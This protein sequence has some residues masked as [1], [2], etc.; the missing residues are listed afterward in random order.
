MFSSN[1]K[2]NNNN[3][4]IGDS[5]TVPLDFFVYLINE[6]VSMSFKKKDNSLEKLGAEVGSR[7]YEGILFQNSLY[8]KK[9][10]R[11]TKFI[12]ILQYAQTKLFPILFGKKGD[13]LQSFTS[14]RKVTF[15]NIY[16]Y[17]FKIVD[18]NSNSIN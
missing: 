12:D 6:Y 8:N 1:K 16:Q 3:A 10:K 18:N 17:P 5:R 13:S 9:E 2:S 14:D 7:L 4:I 11:E 15:I